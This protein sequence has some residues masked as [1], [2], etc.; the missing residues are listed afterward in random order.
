ME[1][2]SNEKIIIA[3]KNRRSVSVSI[4]GIPLAVHSKMKEYM[5]KIRYEHNKSYSLKEAYREFLIEKT[6]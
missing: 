3:K 6:K 1:I 5:N 2:K 4:V